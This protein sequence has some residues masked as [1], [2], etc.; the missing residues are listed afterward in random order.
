MYTSLVFYS[1]DWIY[2]SNG[3]L[4][5][6]SISDLLKPCTPPGYTGC[7]MYVDYADCNPINASTDN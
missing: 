7:L 6:G 3:P 5:N 1:S 4:I 2:D